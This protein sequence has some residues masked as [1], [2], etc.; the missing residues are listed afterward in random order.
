[1]VWRGGAR[2]GKPSTTLRRCS[3]LVAMRLLVTGGAGYIGS[4]VTTLLL[5]DGHDVTVLDDLSSSQESAVPAGA[6]FVEGRVQDLVED[7][8]DSRQYDGVL[9]FAAFIQVEESLRTPE[10]YWDNNVVASIKLV[11]AMVRRGVPRLVFSP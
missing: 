4:T 6:E 2:V 7:V 3:K 8:L 5:D 11:D 1:M 10:S 9:H